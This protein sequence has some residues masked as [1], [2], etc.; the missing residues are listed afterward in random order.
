MDRRL[1]LPWYALLFPITQL[2]LWWCMMSLVLADEAAGAAWIVAGVFL[3][4]LC[5]VT[6]LL[7]FKALRQSTQLHMTLQRQQLVESS[8]EAQR[9][10]N[11]ALEQAAE[12]AAHV[13]REL[14]ARL[15]EAAELL[16]DHRTEAAR[17]CMDSTPALY[18]PPARSCAH[19]VADAILSEKLALCRRETLPV[20]CQV[21]IPAELQIPGAEL[22]AV[23]GNLMDNAIEACRRL[24]EDVTG[25]ITVRGRVNG[26]FLTLRV[27][28]PVSGGETAA[29]AGGTLLDHHG[30]GLSIV[31]QIAERR[32]GRLTVEQTDGRFVATAWLGAAE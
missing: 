22:C 12:E 7:L 4:L 20:D 5:V 10:R 1:R 32:G 26:G 9:K 19:P 25:G 18:P 31:R 15:L 2:S 16:Q 29:P 28:N 30:W 23:L 14:S 21:Q 13:R 27:Q 6:D 11:Q 24:P 3:L 8:L 17:S